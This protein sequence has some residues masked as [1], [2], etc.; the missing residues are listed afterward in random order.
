MPKITLLP[1]VLTMMRNVYHGS[2][3]FK[4]ALIEDDM[5]VVKLQLYRF[6]SGTFN[7]L[8]SFEMLR[9]N[10]VESFEAMYH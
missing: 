2:Q 10:T 6:R 1:V 8:A 7:Q 3:V 5:M 4:Y 9:A